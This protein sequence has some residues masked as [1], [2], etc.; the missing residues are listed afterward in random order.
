MKTHL[1]LTLISASL[2]TACGGSSGSSSPAVPA[3]QAPVASQV[4]I[5]DSNGGALLHND[6]LQASYVYSD[7]DDDA[8]GHSIASW[9]VDGQFKAMSSGFKPGYDAIGKYVTLSIQPVAAYGVKQGEEVKVTIGPIVEHQTQ[10]LVNTRLEQISSGLNTADL[11]ITDG[12][13]EGTIKLSNARSYGVPVQMKDKWL[14]PAMWNTDPDRPMNNV[15]GFLFTDGT[16]DGSKKILLP[17][18]PELF[19]NH[20][21]NFGNKVLFSGVDDTHGDELWVTDG[22]AAGTKQIKD[23][24]DAGG[25]ED[26]HPDQFTVIGAQAYFSAKIDANNKV[27][28]V[29]DGT[30]AGTKRV[31]P[32][33]YNPQMLKNFN[34]K[35]IFKAADHADNFTSLI[36]M[37]FNPAD[38][39]VSSLGVPHSTAV[40]ISAS[41]SLIVI[42]AGSPADKKIWVSKG[43]A[44]D[45]QQITSPEI[46]PNTIIET[47]LG[48]YM[49]TTMVNGLDNTSF[50]KI[51][52]VDDL[53]NFSL[54][55]STDYRA[56]NPTV[57]N[58]T[59]YARIIDNTGDSELHA[60]DG[61]EFKKIADVNPNGAG[62]L[63]LTYYLDQFITVNGSLLFIGNDDEHGSELWKTRGDE[64]ST[65]LFKEFT[66]G[67]NGS[68]IEL[69]PQSLT[70]G[71]NE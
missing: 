69:N 6:V 1:T 55:G 24:Y 33:I 18:A 29:T 44:G 67:T 66:P 25:G 45:A 38:N 15:S 31:E 52:D 54:N 46:I 26:S 19:P 23:L 11:Y 65:A 50:W 27:L 71:P 60:I 14:I 41:D 22:T 63:P 9:Y 39:S 2:L 20:L 40:S 64:S 56:Y 53:Q 3:N 61:S 21:T 70:S 36:A 12:E 59:I 51:N 37:V 5:I 57:F 17:N 35:L 43:I 47:S 58:N 16:A 30:A 48:L 28:W 34:G 68:A 49:T 32:A 42:T 62:V 10:L 8:Q 13:P 4:S 7:A